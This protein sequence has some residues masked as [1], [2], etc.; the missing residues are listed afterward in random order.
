MKAFL[1]FETRLEHSSTIL[2][3]EITLVKYKNPTLKLFYTYTFLIQRI[4]KQPA[5]LN[6]PI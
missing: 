1:N 3:P 2:Y 5:V 4:L 6:E